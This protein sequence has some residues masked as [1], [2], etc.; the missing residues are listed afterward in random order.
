MLQSERL[1]AHAVGERGIVAAMEA[2]FISAWDAVVIS[3]A[4]I[5]MIVLALRLMVRAAKLEDIPRHIGV[6]VG[7][8]IALTILP[9]VILS[10][11]NALSVAQRLGIAALC[12]GIIFLL[13]ALQRKPRNAGRK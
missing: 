9:A 4:L 10:L 8:V 2:R 3:A 1:G 13:E 12:L 6:I 5:A 11:W 7:F